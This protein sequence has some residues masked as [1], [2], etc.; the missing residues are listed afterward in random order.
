[1][2]PGR[3]LGFAKVAAGE[4]RS[5]FGETEISKRFALPAAQGSMPYFLMYVFYGFYLRILCS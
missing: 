4:A 3:D 5:D 1:M 2:V